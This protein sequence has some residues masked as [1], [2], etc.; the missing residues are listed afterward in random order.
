MVD[1]AVLRK[2]AQDLRTF[3]RQIRSDNEV[4]PYPTAGDDAGLLEEA[5]KRM[6]EAADEIEHL[7]QSSS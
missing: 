6:E 7:R 3:A 5:A 1:T 2:L 4:I